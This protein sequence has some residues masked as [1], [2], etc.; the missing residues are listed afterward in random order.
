M[1]AGAASVALN[2]SRE[3]SKRGHTIHCW[4]LDDVLAHPSKPERFGA[5]IFAIA[6]AR[7]ILRESDQYDVVNLHAPW[8]CAYGMLHRIFRPKNSPPY[9]MTMQG[10]EE[11]YVQAMTLEHRKGRAWQFGW[12]NRVWHRIY[13]QTMYDLS[14][15]SADYGT[16]ANREGAALADAHSRSRSGRICY[17]PNGVEERF[18]AA[19]EY[20]D[21]TPL[22]LLFVGTWLDRKGIYYLA[23][24]FNSLARLLPTIDLTV[25]GCLS[26]EEDV[27]KIFAPEVRNRV[28][29]VQFVSRDEMPSLYATHDIFVFPS[30]VEGM[31]L[32]LLEAMAAG[33]PVVTTNTCG[34]ADLVEDELNGLLVP[35][36][37]AEALVSAIE[38]LCQ[39]PKL[40]KHLGENAQQSAREFTWEKA[41]EQLE[42]V[43]SLAVSQAGAE[44]SNGRDGGKACGDRS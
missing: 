40:R 12:K 43:L 29:V 39:S 5:L 32:T 28:R 18:F 42:R 44:R 20:A 30:L 4:F 10:S 26:P 35:P 14:I 11:R 25:A 41:A 22:R 16:V 34:M 19:R 37:N 17:V 27:K 9:V 6:I 13:H 31:P 21:K 33:M 23:D 2:N 7:R 1:E 36:A 38:R 8:G 3:L 24:A 15:W